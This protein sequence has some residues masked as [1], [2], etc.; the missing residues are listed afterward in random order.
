VTFHGLPANLYEAKQRQPTLEPS[1]AK[2]PSPRMKCPQITESVR[3]ISKCTQK[4]NNTSLYPQPTSATIESQ[5]DASFQVLVNN[6]FMSIH[7]PSRHS[8]RQRISSIGSLLILL[9]IA[10]SKEHV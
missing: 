6:L 9:G 5:L 4:V 1:T 8:E 3:L 7:T 2:H 10:L